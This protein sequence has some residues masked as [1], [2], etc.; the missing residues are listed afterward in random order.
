MSKC[1][2]N[3]HISIQIKGDKHIMHQHIYLL[4][5]DEEL[6]KFQ[7]KNGGKT[8]SKLKLGEMTLNPKYNLQMH[9]KGENESS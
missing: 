2:L 4:A 6:V 5:L 8:H 7:E 9:A 3:Q 1:H